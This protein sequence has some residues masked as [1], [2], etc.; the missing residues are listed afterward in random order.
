MKQFNKLLLVAMIGFGTVTAGLFNDACAAAKNAPAKFTMPRQLVS[1]LIVE[2]PKLGAAKVDQ[3]L[4]TLEE[5][6]SSTKANYET[7]IKKNQPKLA[8]YSY[9]DLSQFRNITDPTVQKL[10][11]DIMADSFRLTNNE[12]KLGIAI[13]Y[14]VIVPKV[15]RYA[16]K[17]VSGYYEILS[18]SSAAKVCV[19]GALKV[20]PDALAERIVKAQAFIKDNPNF[21]KI[22]EVKT[23]SQNCLA[24][25]L[26]GADNTPA[27]PSGKKLNDKFLK[28]YQLSA[29][30]YKA[31][32][33]GTVMTEY[34][35]VLKQSKFMKTNQI[36]D[37]V[38]K[39]QP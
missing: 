22:A 35:N 27:F 15:T 21:S 38:K 26:L 29:T 11:T 25:Y 4:T 36:T 13:E 34:L 19:D 14:P 23:I 5:L 2:S 8:K 12:G 1:Y 24:L 37:F 20:T 9:R 30:K 6:W 3:S 28:S 7:Q 18:S 39:Q 10:L 32:P 16:S 17:P 31:A 33:L